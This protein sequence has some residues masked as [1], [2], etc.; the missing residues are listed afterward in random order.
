MRPGSQIYNSPFEGPRLINAEAD[1]ELL[2]RIDYARKFTALKRLD[3]PDDD[4]N[5]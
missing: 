4:D 2:A 1:K 3:N 5:D